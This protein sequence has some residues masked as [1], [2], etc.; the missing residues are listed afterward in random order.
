M[1]ASNE[2]PINTAENVP[3]R[4]ILSTPVEFLFIGTGIFPTTSGVSALA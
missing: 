1:A 2:D 3:F 4:Y